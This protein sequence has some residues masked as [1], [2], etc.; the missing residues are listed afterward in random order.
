RYASARD[1]HDAVERFLDGNRDVKA[2]EQMAA[3]HAKTA[4]EAVR[5][6]STSPP[7][8]ELAIRELGAALALDPSHA[9]A[10]ETLTRLMLDVPAEM[11]AEARREFAQTPR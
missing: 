5:L 8:R 11:S 10:I 3:E 9:G 4:E 7:M 2:R 6:A 1:V